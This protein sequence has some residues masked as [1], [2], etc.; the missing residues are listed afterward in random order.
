MVLFKRSVVRIGNSAWIHHGDGLWIALGDLRGDALRD[1]CVRLRY[2]LLHTRIDL[3]T[4]PD[5]IQI[6]RDPIRFDDLKPGQ[7]RGVCARY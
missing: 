5:W 7:D 6:K 3:E 1:F 4:L 2:P